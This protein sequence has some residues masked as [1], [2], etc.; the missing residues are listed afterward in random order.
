MAVTMKSTVLFTNKINGI[1]L[2]DMTTHAVYL[3]P[4]YGEACYN[5]VLPYFMKGIHLKLKFYSYCVV[6]SGV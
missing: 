6:I 5:T 4:Q 3:N 1:I 2:G